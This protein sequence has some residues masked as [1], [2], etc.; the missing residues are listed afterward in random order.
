MAN[1]YTYSF[2]GTL[3]RTSTSGGGAESVS[4]SGAFTV[5]YTD[6]NPRIYNAT[7][8]VDQSGTSRGQIFE[9]VDPDGTNTYVASFNL[10]NSIANTQILDV[11]YNGREP[12]N[13]SNT[14]Y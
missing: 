11:T 7:A 1:V 6:A 3:P 10:F 8:R 14:R 4:I 9:R 13:F 12:V 5:D 2:N